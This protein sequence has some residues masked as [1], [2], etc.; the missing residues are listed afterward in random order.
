MFIAVFFPSGLRGDLHRYCRIGIEFCQKLGSLVFVDWVSYRRLSR[1]F[2][3]P[4]SLV[5]D[6]D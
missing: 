2:V 5:V 6:L 3:E 1:D 4:G